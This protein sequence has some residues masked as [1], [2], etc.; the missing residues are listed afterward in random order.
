MFVECSKVNR[1]DAKT[2]LS[3]PRVPTQ[4]HVQLLTELSD[5]FVCKKCFGTVM[6]P[7]VHAITLASMH[8][9]KHDQT[10]HSVQERV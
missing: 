5:G 10:H 3:W 9:H 6:A 4:D 1:F 7:D 8:S 2:L